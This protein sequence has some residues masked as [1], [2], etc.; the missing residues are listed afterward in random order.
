VKKSTFATCRFNN[1][2]AKITSHTQ[3]K[4]KQT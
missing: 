2:S 1:T 3:T 4:G